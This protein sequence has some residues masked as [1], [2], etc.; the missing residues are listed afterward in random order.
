MKIKEVEQLVGI[1]VNNIRFYEEMGL[2]Q[3][4]RD[5]ENKYRDFQ[6][7]DIERLKEI[8]LF[9]SLGITIEEIKRY[10]KDEISLDEMMDHQVK[11]LNLQHID[12]QMKS[13][14]CEEIK[15]HKVPI[16]AYSVK[17]YGDYM[18]HKKKHTP[19]EEAKGLL[20][21]WN[22]MQYSKKKLGNVAKDV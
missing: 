2:I 16:V 22:K 20:A 14:I 19:M 5:P 11:E 7:K 8:K 4:K 3:I 18:E 10:Y 17:Q 12:M 9:R 15:I 21:T 6:T 13:K 1:H